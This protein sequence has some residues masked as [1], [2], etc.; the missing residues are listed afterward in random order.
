MEAIDEKI[1]NLQNQVDYEKMMPISNC[2]SLAR[3]EIELA[4]LYN[5][6]GEKDKANQLLEDAK[7]ALTDPMC[8]ESRDK[9]RVL[10]QLSFIMGGT[11]GAALQNPYMQV[12]TS[13][14]IYIRFMGLIILMLGYAVLYILG[15]FGYITN[16][17]L[18]NILVFVVFIV[19]LI[20]G[21]VIQ[22]M[23]VR[24]ARSR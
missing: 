23:Y 14:P 5:R 11:S 19:S 7:N 17:I 13:I 2:A 20:A 24:K 8:P 10:N 4:T 1:Q 9:R 16:D 15:Y 22:R 18:F 6:K 21:S 12:R 3:M